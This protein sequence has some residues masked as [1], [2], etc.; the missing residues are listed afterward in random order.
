MSIFK[1]AKQVSLFDVWSSL[2]LSIKSS[3]GMKAHS[4]T[5]PSCYDAKSASSTKVA[6]DDENGLWY[7]FAC[8]A[9]GD[10]INLVREHQG[11]S[12][13]EAAEWITKQSRE[14]FKN[15]ADNYKQKTRESRPRY[16]INE[17]DRRKARAL[18]I[19][20]SEGAKRM[21]PVT[22]QYLTGRGIS[23]EL[24]KANWRKKLIGTSTI[25]PSKMMEIAL[26]MLPE[27]ATQKD[28]YIMYKSLLYRPAV[29]L[30]RN[31]SGIVTSAEFRSIKKSAA[32]KS[33]RR[34]KAELPWV[35][36]GDCHNTAIVEGCIDAL[37]LQTLGFSGTVVSVPGV[38]CWRDTWKDLIKG[39]CW[40]AFDADKAGDM[41]SEKLAEKLGIHTTRRK[42][43]GCNDWN[44]LLMNKQQERQEDV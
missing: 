23:R 30:Y 44:E 18:T 5:C 31:K 28:K 35:L 36:N 20:A 6:I 43:A 27:T 16:E 39:G 38:Q 8:G 4:S 41:A 19:L 21:C 22:M 12:A 13:I 34:G 42:P 7:C 14:D 11:L 15:I 32:S 24:I 25:A 10:V 37:S 3:T 1:A 29:F 17:E 26:L 2:H 40:L 9:G 33:I